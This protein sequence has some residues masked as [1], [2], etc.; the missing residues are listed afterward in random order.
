MDTLTQD[1][2]RI[3]T[4]IER[5]VVRSQVKRTTELYLIAEESEVSL[6]KTTTIVPDLIRR[7]HLKCFTEKWHDYCYI[8]PGALQDI[9]AHL[10]PCQPF[11][12]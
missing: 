3:L 12:L 4:A 5:S 7:K 1:E 9:P 10:T 11:G 6:A 2:Q 8:V